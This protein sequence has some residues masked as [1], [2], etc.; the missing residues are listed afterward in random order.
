MKKYDLLWNCKN[1]IKFQAQR[2]TNQMY[3][4]K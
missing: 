4:S 3:S 1:A 2:T